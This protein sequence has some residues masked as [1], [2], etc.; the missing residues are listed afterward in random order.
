MDAATD[1][2]R[3]NAIDP[4]DVY[5]SIDTTR[6]EHTDVDVID[7]YYVDYCGF[8]WYTATAGGIIGAAKCDLLSSTNRCDRHSV[9]YSNT[10]AD[11]ASTT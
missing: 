6:D 7:R 3:T 9:R 4:T 8:N 2:A 10:W 11:G 5:T 1:Y